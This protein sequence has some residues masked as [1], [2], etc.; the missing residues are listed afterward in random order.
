MRNQ[1]EEQA[2][3]DEASH[4]ADVIDGQIPLDGPKI[5]GDVDGVWQILSGDSTDEL[6]RFVQLLYSLELVSPK[7]CFGD[8]DPTDAERRMSG[9]I[10]RA[11]V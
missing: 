2:L 4:L 9:E 11:H 3:W 8:V 7:I 10:G 5:E 1:N 6:E